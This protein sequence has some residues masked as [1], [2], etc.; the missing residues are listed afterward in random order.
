M[1]GRHTS[2]APLRVAIIGFGKMGLNHAKAIQACPQAQLVAVAD[3]LVEP[4]RRRLAV[5]SPVRWFASADELLETVRPHV[6]H[7]VTPPSTH[8]DMARLCLAHGAHVYVEK[9]FTTTSTEA[10]V[11]LDEA[12]RLGLL[13]C[14]GHQMLFEGPARAL[15]ASLGLIGR[16]VHVESYFSFRTVRRSRDGRSPLSPIDQLLDILPH[17]IYTLLDVLATAAPEEAAELAAMDVRAD[18]E[19]RGLIRAGDVTATL[20]V[21]LRGR[22]IE[23]YLRVV[24]TNGALRAD[25]VRG[26]VIRLPGPGT[27]AIAIVLNPYREALQTVFGS[28]RGFAR[29]IFDKKKGYPGLAELFGAFYSAI[30]QQSPSPISPDSIRQT[31]ELCARASC[32]LQ[33]ADGDRERRATLDLTERERRLPPLLGGKG[34]VVVTGGTGLLGRPVVAELRRHGFPVRVLARRVPPPSSREAGVEYISADLSRE[35]EPRL[36]ADVSTIVHCAAA[37]AGDKDAHEKNTVGATRQLLHVSAAAG[38]RRF[39][40]IS[41]LAVLKTG[42]SVAGPVD[43]RTPVD[44]N[45]PARGPYVWA[46]AESERVAVHEGR[47]LGVTVRVIRPG[48]LVDF[49]AYEPPGRLGRELGPVF[50][51]VGPRSGPLSVCDVRTGAAVIRCAVEDVDALPPVVNVVEPAPPTRTQLVSMWLERRPDLKVFWLPAWVLSAVSPVAVLAQR[52]FRP[53]ATALD[54]A[55]A[56]SSERYDTTLVAQVLARAQVAP[57]CDGGCRAMTQ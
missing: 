6:A 56:F 24:G 41:S 14:A 11:V 29:H 34:R 37:S 39:I 22:P 3:P 13:V 35:L 1:D 43:E 31:V 8:A 12:R 16:V 55:A 54:V 30:E 20:I 46:K 27:S 53:H 5:P 51:A 23:S 7:V 40:H 19:V 33:E 36:F 44:A 18:G 9:P 2:G 49:D 42:G 38:V 45:N 50:L 17:P 10:A 26:T 32:L 28:T 47:A 4:S 48:P 15:A 21:T 25:F 52:L 57:R